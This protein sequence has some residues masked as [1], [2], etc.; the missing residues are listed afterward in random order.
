MDWGEI[1]CSSTSSERVELEID[2]VMPL[3]PNKSK[4]QAECFDPD[5]V[6][7]IAEDYRYD[8]LEQVEVGRCAN[9]NSEI[10]FSR[11][12]IREC[13]VKW[14]G[15]GL[16]T[17][18]YCETKKDCEKFGDN[19]SCDLVNHRCSSVAQQLED[20]FLTCFVDSLIPILRS[21]LISII[22]ELDG[23][24]FF[25]TTEELVSRIRN[26]ID[27]E[28]VISPDGITAPCQDR[29]V[30]EFGAPSNQT[31]FSCEGVG[32]RF[33][34]T[35]KYPLECNEL[36]RNC[37]SFFAY[38]RIQEICNSSLFCNWDKEITDPEICEAEEEM[39]MFCLNETN[40]VL[41]PIPVTSQSECEET[42]ICVLSD[43]SYL[44]DL[45]DEE[46][47]EIDVRPCLLTGTCGHCIDPD[48]IF[49]VVKETA[50]LVRLSTPER[51]CVFPMRPHNTPG[52][53]HIRGS[54]N[55]D[56][57]ARRGCIAAFT[58]E[59]PSICTFISSEECESANGHWVNIPF[60][61]ED[62]V[63]EGE[64]FCAQPFS[65]PNQV[66]H[67][68]KIGC[69]N[70]S[71]SPE[72]VGE[73]ENHKNLSGTPYKMEWREPKMVAEYVEARGLDYSSFDFL[74]AQMENVVNTWVYSQS[75]FCY[76]QI[77]TP[78]LWYLS[79][80]C[81]VPLDEH[82]EVDT[83]NISSVGLVEVSETEFA[84]STIGIW[85]PGTNLSVMFFNG[86]LLT[87]TNDTELLTCVPGYIFNVFRSEFVGKPPQ[88]PVTVFGDPNTVDP[89]S[90]RN[91]HGASVGVIVGDGI[92]VSPSTDFTLTRDMSMLIYFR[93]SEH[94]AKSDNKKYTVLDLG[95]EVLDPSQ[96]KNPGVLEVRPD[97]SLESASHTTATNVSIEEDNGLE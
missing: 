46:C 59:R 67:P 92:F 19:I 2:R 37:L 8:L 74:V 18:Y 57:V 13:E 14:Y 34:N 3:T 32:C 27:I 28:M 47:R 21:A 4:I 88:K 29:W 90:V 83:I 87:F 16:T 69:E 54:E 53:S 39:C 9:F 84:N 48:N 5:C 62:C 94:D 60:N 38:D 36:D 89:D 71:E 65:Y 82:L 43:G 1:C 56:F 15:E 79:N 10:F 45:S 93:V 75:F 91:E 23:G 76:F 20:G 26:I 81:L 73:W 31:C 6:E 97:P 52:C 61:E 12:A 25:M 68:S 55:Y 17:G 95:I 41:P 44:F 49:L 63:G 77:N 40:C 66:A 50:D 33:W 42:T 80:Q 7:I 64:I 86:E 35:C 24:E 85:C 78:Y 30:L 51:V 72:S 58:C 96:K 22:Q 11:D 70:C